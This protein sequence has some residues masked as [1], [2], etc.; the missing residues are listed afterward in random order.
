MSTAP[1][2]SEEPELGDEPAQLRRL[3]DVTKAHLH[4]VQAEK[5]Q[6]ILA[7]KQA[8]EKM[9]EQRQVA[10]KEKDDLQAKFEEERVQAKQ[11]K[12]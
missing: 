2:P 6:A 12:E 9:V 8:Q 10:Q 5:Y 4:R 7:L 1:P 3:V 11:E